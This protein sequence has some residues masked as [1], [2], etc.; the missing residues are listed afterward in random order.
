MGAILA[1]LSNPVVLSLVTSVG[2]SAASAGAA[3]LATQQSPA[4]ASVGVAIAAGLAWWKGHSQTQKALIKVV[5]D[6][7]N[8]VKVV[9]DTVLAPKVTEPLR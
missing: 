6:T 5:N 8:G 7:D 3:W 9:A 4:L 2:L 1:I